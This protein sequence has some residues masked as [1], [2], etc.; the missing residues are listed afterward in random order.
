MTTT[1]RLTSI[2]SIWGSSSHDVMAARRDGTGPGWEC[3][4]AR[5][6]DRSCPA[7]S[8]RTAGFTFDVYARVSADCGRGDPAYR[9]LIVWLWYSK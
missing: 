5:S 6:P 1:P 8:L 9:V 2:S 4:S 3:S 7:G